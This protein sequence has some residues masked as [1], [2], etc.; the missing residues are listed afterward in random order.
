MDK[1]ACHRWAR[2]ELGRCGA[3]P[4]TD[5]GDRAITKS[6]PEPRWASRPHG[7]PPSTRNPHGRRSGAP[8]VTQGPPCIRIEGANRGWSGRR[9]LNPRPPAPSLG[10]EVAEYELSLAER[11]RFTESPLSTLGCRGT[12][13]AQ[14]LGSPYRDSAATV[15]LVGTR[16]AVVCS[17]TS[18]AAFASCGPARS[19]VRVPAPDSDRRRPDA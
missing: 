12:V 13:S 17:D 9:D 15:I 6:A 7:P 11:P 5:G 10:V 1:S 18:W 19:P 3:A 2:F 16:G 8:P 4:S 14:R